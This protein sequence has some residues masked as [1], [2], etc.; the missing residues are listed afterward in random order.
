MYKN[1]SKWKYTKLFV[2]FTKNMKLYYSTRKYS[3][4]V[5]NRAIKYLYKN[6]VYQFAIN[7]LFLCFLNLNHVEFQSVPRLLYTRI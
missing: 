7:T 6:Q 4:V 5:I 3:R 1:K 2:N